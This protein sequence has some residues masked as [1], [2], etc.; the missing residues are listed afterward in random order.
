MRDEERVSV[1]VTT[2]LMEEAE[3]CDR[4]AIF[5]EGNVVAMGTP[6][7]LRSEIGGDVIVLETPS[8]EPLA[9]KIRQRFG[10]EPKVAV[11]DGKVRLERASGHRFITELVEAFPGEIDS[12][13]VSKPTLEDVF[14]RRTGHR[15]WS[16]DADAS[17]DGATVKTAKAKGKKR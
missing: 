14:I 16:E 1:L 6:L 2:H 10:A 15:F 4:L 9:A 8:P 5:S 17:A 11:L 3:K 7:E 12:V 13:S